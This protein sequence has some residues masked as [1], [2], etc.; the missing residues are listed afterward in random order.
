MNFTPSL[1]Y[2]AFKTLKVI[3]NNFCS[4]IYVK[5]HWKFEEG[6]LYLA[7]DESPEYSSYRGIY[8]GDFVTALRYYYGN[9]IVSNPLDYEDVYILGLFSPSAPGTRDCVVLADHGWR[10]NGATLLYTIEE[11]TDIRFRKMFHTIKL[12]E[13]PAL[14][15]EL[16]QQGYPQIKG[17]INSIR[18]FKTA[19]VSP[20]LTIANGLAGKLIGSFYEPEEL[21]D[22]YPI[23]LPRLYRYY[24]ITTALMMRLL[25][26]G[27]PIHLMLFSYWG[28]RATTRQLEL[29]RLS[30]VLAYDKSGYE[31]FLSKLFEKYSDIWYY[32]FFS[33]PLNHYNKFRLNAKKRTKNLGK[34]VELASTIDIP[35]N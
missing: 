35:S 12:R 17:V 1:A 27:Y 26:E 7:A 5:S 14:L 30:A 25:K 3:D 31:H 20:Y 19:I 10:A 13:V 28:P 11:L 4:P 2:L 32:N 18:E 9:D 6:L 33:S 23:V 21:I 29:M 24:E 15:E 34:L 22:T 8:A 16:E